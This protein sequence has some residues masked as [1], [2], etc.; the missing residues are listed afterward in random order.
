MSEDFLTRWARLKRESTARAAPRSDASVTD[1]TPEPLDPCGASP[2]DLATLPPLESISAESS[3]AAFLRAGVPEDLTRAALRS[4]W[5]T[6]PVIRDFVGI[7]E[8]QWDFNAEGAIAGFSSLSVGEYARYVAARA[9]RDEP[10]VPAAQEG[11]DPGEDESDNTSAP[12]PARECHA[13]TSTTI[14]ALQSPP[15]ARESTNQAQIASASPEKASQT[16]RPSPMKRTHGS[17]LPK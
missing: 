14:P 1:A 2:V 16:S 11:D 4:A 5:V 8:N 7:A 10:G 6:D 13:A 12:R 17:A 3:I 9:L 15:S